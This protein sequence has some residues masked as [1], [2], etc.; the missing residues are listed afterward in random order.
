MSRQGQAESLRLRAS[1][2]ARLDSTARSLQALQAAQASARVAAA[3]ANHVPNGL[4][5]GGLEVLTG[6]N[7][8]WDGA[9]T[10]AAYGNY[11][12]IKQ[13]K[14]QAILNWQTFN[15]GRDTTLNFDQSSGGVDAGKWVAFNNVLDPSGTPSQILGSITAQGQVYVINQNGIIFGGASQVN[16]RSLVASSL[17]FNEA[18]YTR[19]LLN[20]PQYNEFQFSALPD[21][22]FTPPSPPPSGR[23][24][25]VIVSPGAQIRTSVNAEGSG[26][27]VALI[28]PNVHNY[29]TISTPSG[30]TILAAG[31]QVGLQAHDAGDPSLRGLDAFVGSVGTYGGSVYNT[32][33]IDVGAGNLTM[34]GKSLQHYGAAVGLT[35]VSL[36]GRIDLNASYN[37]V[38]NVDYNPIT[39]PNQPAFLNRTTGDVNV[40]P[41]SIT[42]VLPDSG[43]PTTSIGLQLP[44]RSK[45]NITGNS[46][47]FGS[48]SVVRASSGDI[49][50][51]AGDWRSV[52]NFV[53]GAGRT[54]YRRGEPNFVFGT[55]SVLVQNGALLDTSGVADVFLPLSQSILNV[56]LRGSELSV[57]PLLRESVI[58][59]LSLTVD[60]RRS[61]W[62][63][64]RY[65]IGTP[66]GDATGFAEIIERTVDQMSANG[67]TI[68]ITAGGQVS[69]QAGSI[70]DVSGG[71]YRNEAGM[72]ET[73]RLTMPGSGL[74]DVADATPDLPFVG[75]Y[76]PLSTVERAKWG[77]TQT[78]RNAL[79]PSGAYYQAETI[80][81]AAGGELNI[82]A[83][84]MNLAGTLTGQTVAGPQQMRPLAQNPAD[85][86]YSQLPSLSTLRLAFT[87]QSPGDFTGVAYPTVSPQPATIVFGGP[88]GSGISSEGPL[89]QIAP[90]FFSTS[91]FGNLEI[92]NAEGDMSV[93]GGAE[94]V[95]PEGGSL[96][97]RGRNFAVDGT[98]VAPGGTVSLTAHMFS[99]YQ[100]AILKSDPFS[101][102]P[103]IS[104]ALG[105]ITIG[106]AA[107]ISTAGLVVDDS[108]ASVG[109]PLRPFA[110][111][112]GRIELVG[113][114]ATTAPGS[115]LDVS[116]GLAVGPSGRYRLGAAGTLKIAAGNDPTLPS[117]LGGRLSLGG[118]MRGYS[119]SHGGTLDITAPLVQVGGA[120][121]HP[122]SLVLSP[123]FFTTG[124]FTQFNLT[125]LGVLPTLEQLNSLRTQTGSELAPD[126]FLPA[127]Y[128]SPGT[129]IRP[130]AEVFVYAA[131]GEVGEEASVRLARL[132]EAL[133]PPVS[134]TFNAPGIDEDFNTADEVTGLPK[135]IGSAKIRGDILVGAGSLIET[136]PG[137][138]LKL[139]GQTVSVVGGLSAPAGQ[140][141]VQG[142]AD[143]DPSV[144]RVSV[145]LGPEARLSVAGTAVLQPASADPFGRVRGE[146][147][148]GGT[149]TVAGNILASAGAV[150]DVSGGSGVL[151]LAPRELGIEITGDSSRARLDTR[152]LARLHRPVAISSD[153]GTLRL[154]GKEM[155]FNE[156]T[157]LG[158]PGGPASSGGSL[159]ISSGRF[160][161]PSEFST[162]ADANLLVSQI[163]QLQLSGTAATGAGFPVFDPSG[164]AIKGIGYF[165]VD[166]MN[167]GGFASLKL[168]GNPDFQGDVSI[169]VTGSLDVASGGVIRGD[170]DIRL[171]SRY[172]KLGQPF[173]APLLPTD[174]VQLFTK[175]DPTNPEYNFAPTPGR[176]TLAATAEFIDV[177]TLSFDGLSR[178]ELRAPGGEIRGNGTLQIAGDLVLEAAQVYPTTL[179]TFSLFAY[180]T[181]TSPGS[182]TFLGSGVPKAPLSAAGTLN[183]QASVI[184]QFG[185][186]LA[187][188]G[189]IVLGWD[190]S[191]T[192][193]VNPIAKATAPTPETRSLVLGPGSVTS[194]AGLDPATGAA[195]LIPYGVSFDGLN[196]IDPSGQNIT[197]GSLL[198]SKEIVLAGDSV[199]VQAGATV[200]LRGGG[201]LFAYQWIEGNGGPIDI[202]SSD[203]QYKEADFDYG[204]SESFAVLPSYTAPVSPYA[205]FNT[206]GQADNLDNNAG[207]REGGYVHQDLG[208]GDRVYLA[209]RPGLPAGYYT[210]L[211]ARYALMPG[212]FLV[213]PFA[214][215][216]NGSHLQSDGSS[217]VAGFQ[218]DGMAA[219]TA[220]PRV[221]TTW[222]VVPASV[223]A[224]RAEYS[225]L[226]ANEFFPRRAAELGLTDVA[227]LPQ[228]SGYLRVTAND[229]LRLE[230]NVLAAPT[231]AGRGALADIAT[232]ANMVIRGDS[233]ASTEPVV[234]SA[235][236]LSRSGIESLLLGG[237]RSGSAITARTPEITLDNAGT[238]L[239][240]PDV[241]LAASRKITLAPGSELSSAGQTSGSV[242]P[243]STAGNGAA[244]RVSADAG[245]SLSRSG[246]TMDP[247]VLLTVGAGAS[248]RGVAATLDS[249]Y[250]FSLDPSAVIS[251]SS[252]ALGAG[253]ISILLNGAGSLAGQLDPVVPHLVI[254]GQTFAN[255]GLADQVTLRTYRGPIDLYG[256]G[257]FGSGAVDNLVLESPELRGFDQGTGTS[258]LIAGRIKLW[259]PNA[260]AATGPLLAPTGTLDLQTG[261]LEIG[262]GKTAVSQFSSV[263]LNAPGGILFTGIG[264]LTTQGALTASTAALAAASGSVQSLTAGGDIAFFDSGFSPQVSSGSG[265]ALTLRGASVLLNPDVFLPSGILSLEAT[266]TGGDVIV[267]GRLDAGGVSQLFYD[268]VA[269]SDGG[270]INIAAR[271]G[272]VQLLA[273]SDLVVNAPSGGGDAGRVSISAPTGIF[274]SSGVL[275]GHAGFGG[276]GG[277]FELDA[278]TVPAFGAL[279]TQLNSG[280]F[281]EGRNFRVRSGPV[282]VTGTSVVRDYRLS[283]DAGNITVEGVVDASGLTGGSI[284]LIASGDVTLAGGSLLDVSAARFSSSG[285]GGQVFI[286]AGSAINGAANAAARIT[287]ADNSTVDLR[288]DDYAAGA[289]TTPGSSAFNGEFT[290]TLHLRAPRTG[291]GAG[292]GI[293]IND[294]QG[295][296]LGASS[297]LA[298]GFKVYQ[299]P[300]GTI[301]SAIQSQI[302]SEAN[303]YLGA[304]GTASANYIAMLG[305]ILASQP[306]L[307]SVFVLAPGAEIVSTSAS[308]DLVLGTSSS[309]S[310]SDWNLAS[311]RYGPKRAPGVLTLRAPRD[312][313]L[314]NAI[315]DGFTPT[316]AS[317]NGSWLW[318]AP[319]SPIA[320]PAG[321]ASALPLNTQSWSY[322]FTAGADLTAADYR[323]V[324]P[325]GSITTGSGGSLRLGKN[326]GNAVFGSGTAALTSTALNNRFQVIRTGTGDI[327]ISASANVTLLNP[328]AAIYTAG[329][330]VADYTSVFAPGDFYLPTILDS[331]NQDS[332]GASQRTSA[333]PYYVQYSMAGGDV[334]ISAGADL[335]RTTGSGASVVDDSS[336]QL[337]SNWLYR[338]GFV[339]PA[340]GDFG[341]GGYTDGPTDRFADPASTTWWVDFSNFFAGI[342]ALGG[343]DIL[344][345]AGR[346][347]ENM[348]AA[349][350][351]NARMPAGTPDASKL[352]E[353]GGGDLLVRAGRNIDAGVYY[354]ESG[355]GA[356]EAGGSIVTNPTRSPSLGIIGGLT[357]PTLQDPLT[358]LPTTLFVGKSTFNVSAR[359]DILLGPIANAFLLPPG[360]NNRYWNK[361]Y[362]T[363]Y[364][365]EATVTVNSF[366]GSVTLRTEAQIP[367]Q[368]STRPLLSLWAETQHVLN[369]NTAAWFHPWLRLA[370]TSVL[371]FDSAVG[372]LPP[373][374]VARAFAGDVSISGN[375]QLFPSPQGT[376]EL[377]AA[378]G[379]NALQPA[380]YSPFLVSGQDTLVWKSST[381]NLS[382]ASPGS[383]AGVANPLAAADVVGRVRT[384]LLGS[385]NVFGGWAAAF[386]ETGSYAAANSADQIKT[387][388]HSSDILHS[389]DTSPLRLYAGMG[390]IEGLTLFSAKAAQIYAGQDVADVSLYV[391]NVRDADVSIVA[392]GRDVL[393]YSASSPLRIAA[394]RAGNAPASGPLAGDIQISGPGALQVVAGRNL[395]LGTGANNPD[396]TGTGITSIGNFRNPFLPF[397]GADLYVAAG[398]GA[399]TGLGAS[400]LRVDDFLATYGVAAPAGASAEQRAALALS[401]LFGI[402]KETATTAAEGGS[403]DAAFA[404]VAAL[405]GS[406]DYFGDV[407]TYS[408]EIK[409]RTGGS[410]TVL[411]PGGGIEM[412]SNILGEPLAPP[413]IVT[414][415]GGEISI[416]TEGDVD[417]G[418][419]RIFTLRGGDITIWSSAG[420]IA[421]GTS[422]KTV[423]TAP[424]TRVVVDLRTGTVET[425][426][427]GLATGGGIGV[428]A[429]VE[430]VPPGT[431]SLLA[432]V[433]TVDAGDAGIRATGDI[434]IAAAQVLNADNISAGGTT[435]GTPAAPVAAVPN[436][437]ALPA[438]ASSTA[439][440]SSAAA[441]VAQQ[442]Q[443][444]GGAPVQDQ[445]AS[446]VTVEVIGYGGGEGS[447]EEKKEGQG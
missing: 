408:R 178:V 302:N 360:I 311:F 175:S 147:L 104:P 370:E 371:G 43:N 3:A 168:G 240:G 273:G 215:T 440:T 395:D 211:P 160:Y 124:G 265:A 179:S 279:T 137:A 345:E 139:A 154:Q 306:G 85:R 166:Q 410:I 406:A 48:S 319:L 309:T 200:D 374:L 292:T 362:F 20:Q 264:G 241:T 425:D 114:N 385:V 12:N 414:E 209:G 99:P 368:A 180:E 430:G 177:G 327:D 305:S 349:I 232:T 388:L 57:S 72:V 135:S 191:E 283:T 105:S 308:G 369:N 409:T 326:Y 404:A 318:L 422:A 121:L 161:V 109:G 337:P 132:P 198:P 257:T 314:N 438:G 106:P 163:R 242:V 310:T 131:P 129:T 287:I 353:L 216:P 405:F 176:G 118:E 223:A 189:K 252:V 36:N 407:S 143:S 148:P 356:L 112:G 426:L 92:E 185:A 272:D 304:S 421:A 61:D 80:T 419:G 363:T 291:A 239:T 225:I 244:V 233:Q 187:P 98:I 432:P 87:G 323:E 429:S 401:T 172:L 378:G 210:L 365:E 380:G 443:Q 328:F 38:A 427:A 375:L 149:L 256:P 59:G 343:G 359:G 156:A 122:D 437:S 312:I 56:V 119:G 75:V 315:S 58:R 316:T 70:L 26:G 30:Q 387:A 144:A 169:A 84:V 91:G 203:P 338:R 219:R 396:G 354:V 433:G 289:A 66:L 322:R 275:E 202:L 330:R 4:R 33:I 14:P 22:T 42:Q 329:V 325:A 186:L 126:Y 192:A 303:T 274:V 136:D 341:L 9:Q 384:S 125:G 44:L 339:D 145:Y 293:G 150:L 18:F 412:A 15:V 250:G 228:D 88:A 164:T 207:A 398:L 444:G 138:T 69:T 10:P 270:R 157:M 357:S 324:V 174:I 379:I 285:Q 77:V 130:R 195:L 221:H 224:A 383:L 352:H 134:V 108:A 146:V 212:A 46:I 218:L 81:G 439:A 24:G 54:V 403:Y 173:V 435:V 37:A 342:G 40:G 47:V 413:G 82:T 245:A 197:D 25:D 377:L 382:D 86:L 65:W 434:T 424:P 60:I 194:V 101:A 151:D 71:Y 21:G 282:T 418:K 441:G 49:S 193:P 344:L 238:P 251:G 97:V 220:G 428:L 347:I 267:G 254:A 416:L 76:S 182:V 51:K 271:D 298:E 269:Y 317:S 127:V 208:A 236:V 262:Q 1:A 226:S 53:D 346:D 94:V 206:S 184:N 258:T 447:E 367:N 332:L 446:I 107:V 399:S 55:G 243:M 400:A 63:L 415:Y 266:G 276:T 246:V 45:I 381:M 364:S 411:A 248:V 165:S 263:L 78:Y 205:P 436:V 321:G 334:R 188:F 29:G 253:Q 214:N 402:F 288:V 117:L 280:G 13:T 141:T 128:I 6:P 297:I 171:Q 35:T 237:T 301:T 103:V 299:A 83:P 295:D 350:P 296:I 95:L 2:Q 420:D 261:L 348:D 391:Q 217:L 260:I 116:G 373:S 229:F 90:D 102:P 231:G 155:L 23:Y 100:A 281:T 41:G 162:S 32:G 79:A 113:Y 340:T 355:T 181:T 123:D 397:D 423:V 142:T 158:Q 268:V 386:S 278:G 445:S 294:I 28:G 335:D 393:P 93:P 313:I 392:A 290:G 5:P 331:G 110:A 372:T 68:S 183:V 442:A 277:V 39:A 159:E 196:W 394:S 111:D 27:L 376:L 96:V 234:L 152:P 247:S 67:G 204:T 133:R 227:R 300:T 52:I 333:V 336:R 222:E 7:A 358:W 284:A 120:P 140:I 153:A 74:I 390:S 31:L 199:N 320:T 167:G 417:I 249:T 213:T 201:D 89:V 8:R 255:L 431:V 235:S 11:V 170:G 62:Y 307:E 16:T 190:G 19:G 115:T 259:N 230:G 361:S 64:G 351:T 366:G 17:P 73:T 286:E 34:A 50:V 389:G